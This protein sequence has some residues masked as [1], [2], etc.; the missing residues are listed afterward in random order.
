MNS[1]LDWEPSEHDQKYFE[2][3]TGR[4][5][6]LLNVLRE[7]V[8]ESVTSQP[9]NEKSTK[10]LPKATAPKSDKGS[11]GGSP[12]TKLRKQRKTP[13]S[14]AGSDGEK[15]SPSSTGKS[16]RSR[17]ADT[18]PLLS[19]TPSVSGVSIKSDLSDICSRMMQSEEVQHLH[20]RIF[21]FGTSQ[22]NRLEGK[23]R[24]LRK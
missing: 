11:P 20:H 19:T 5:P 7:S 10:S 12:P 15:N 1:D 21:R 9:D 3:L 18:T 13:S 23:E 8:T 24:E 16:N 2:R 14:T 22:L 4:M 6:I 17:K